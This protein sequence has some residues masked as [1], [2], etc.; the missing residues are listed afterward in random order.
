MLATIDLTPGVAS[1][2]PGVFCLGTGQLAS[3][4]CGSFPT[5]PAIGGFVRYLL[6]L[7]RQ[8]CLTEKDVRFYGMLRC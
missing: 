6:K 8:D 2:T 3:T 1:A 4:R 5:V 7:A